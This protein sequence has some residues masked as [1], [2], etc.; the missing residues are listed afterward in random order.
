MDGTDLR[1]ALTA[2]NGCLDTCDSTVG[3]QPSL[4]VQTAAFIVPRWRQS[5]A[6]IM[7]FRCHSGFV[8]VPVSRSTR[9]GALALPFLLGYLGWA[10]RKMSFWRQRN[11]RPG[12]VID[13]RAGNMN[14]AFPEVGWIIGPGSD[15]HPDGGSVGQGSCGAMKRLLWRQHVVRI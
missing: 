12:K 8:F 1:S 3:P 11:R 10:W 2:P 7:P 4:I 6:R 9:R 14:R 15:V 5:D 13:H